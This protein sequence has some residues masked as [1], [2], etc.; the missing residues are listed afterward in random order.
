MRRSLYGSGRIMEFLNHIF[1][2]LLWRPKRLVENLDVLYFSQLTVWS[3]TWKTVLG[4]YV[5]TTNADDQR[6][7]DKRFRYPKLWSLLFLPEWK[8]GVLFTN[9]LYHLRSKS[10]VEFPTMWTIDKKYGNCKFTMCCS[11]FFPRHPFSFRKMAN[12][13]IPI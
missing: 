10:F 4:Q 3:L 9:P 6:L 1:G 13:S 2:M 11:R 5:R 7:K 12:S 8:L